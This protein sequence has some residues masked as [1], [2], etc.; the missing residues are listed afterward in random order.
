LADAIDW[1]WI[2]G[3]L[4]GRFSLE[5]RPANRDALHGGAS[6]T[7]VLT[8]LVTA[9]PSDTKLGIETSPNFGCNF[10]SIKSRADALANLPGPGKV[11]P[12]R[13]CGHK[14]MKRATSMRQ[15]SLV[16]TE[17]GFFN[18]QFCQ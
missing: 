10:N 5:G 15:P 2:D 3:E 12:E 7:V 13:G 17:G 6:A 16:E 11:V 4:A 9:S 1:G 8:G 14:A 18:D